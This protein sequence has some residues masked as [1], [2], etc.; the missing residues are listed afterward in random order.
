[1]QDTRAGVSP[2]AEIPGYV[3]KG[4]ELVADGQE[5]YR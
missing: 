5:G 1:M 4:A 3:Y 2:F